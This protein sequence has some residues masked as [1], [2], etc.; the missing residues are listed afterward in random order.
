MTD[1]TPAERIWREPHELPQAAGW[2]IV[3]RIDEP[4]ERIRA[5]GQGHW[6]TP[7]PDGWISSD[8][9]YRWHHLPVAALGSDEE[10]N[11]LEEM[12]EVEALKP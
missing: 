10:R 1:T 6:W 7:L 4:G 5:W 8:N 2:Y 9:V 12:R 11:P 3:E